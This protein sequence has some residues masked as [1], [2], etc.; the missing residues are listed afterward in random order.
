MAFFRVCVM[1]AVMSVAAQDAAFETMPLWPD[2]PPSGNGLSGPERAGGCVGNISEAKLYVYLP[3]ADKATGAAVVVTPG[4]G[5]GVVCEKTEGHDI[6]QILEPLGIATIIV[7]YRLPNGNHKVP[8]DDARRA[9]RTVR[10]NAKAW[11][12]DPKRV[13]VWGF[14]AGGHLSSTVAT[15]FD[16]GDA[17]AADLIER[18][19]SRPDFAILFYPVISMEEGVTHG[20]SRRNLLGPT[21]S[22][23][24]VSRYNNDAR[25]SKDTPP[26]FLL[27]AGDDGAVPI[28]NALRFHRAL[29]AHKVSAEVLLFEKG[30]HGPGAFTRN[31]SWRGA[32]D[33]WLKRRG[34]L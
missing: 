30:G 31:P 18:Q 5:Y 4:G 7:H 33:A 23:D 19:S 14:S 25:V 32:F 12:V 22:P 11:R 3:P 27:H 10:H 28:A 8:A 9:I 24:L 2:G 16:A 21:P 6:A 29:V 34:L 13:G 15:V 20:G 17:T 1:F 26:V